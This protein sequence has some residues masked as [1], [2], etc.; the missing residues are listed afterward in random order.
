MSA[1]CAG[2]SAQI[3]PNQA[4]LSCS[5]FQR[6]WHQQTFISYPCRKGCSW[7]ALKQLLIKVWH[8]CWIT[9][10]LLML[11]LIQLSP[12]WLWVWELN[13][14][15]DREL[16]TDKSSWAVPLLRQSTYFSSQHTRCSIN[17][18]MKKK[19]LSPFNLGMIEAPLN[20]WPREPCTSWNI[21]WHEMEAQMLLW[22]IRQRHSRR[23]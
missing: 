13:R 8:G 12:S 3:F 5:F 1:S 23:K 22:D 17:E 15:P 2:D 16:G 10:K 11:I 20:K 6:K 7:A 18:Q 21:W 4:N 19:S 9:N 14:W